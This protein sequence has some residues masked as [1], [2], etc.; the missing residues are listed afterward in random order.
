MN[1]PDPGFPILHAAAAVAVLTYCSVLLLL[2]LLHFKIFLSRVTGR[3]L[4]YPAGKTAALFRERQRRTDELQRA[5]SSDGDTMSFPAE[6]NRIELWKVCLV[7]CAVFLTV[8]VLLI[9]FFNKKH[10]KT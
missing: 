1:F 7:L 5:G 2:V 3:I 10:I 9:R 4:Y 6:N 8:E